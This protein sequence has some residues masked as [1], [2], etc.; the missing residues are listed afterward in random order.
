MKDETTPSLQAR[1][2]SFIAENTS[3]RIRERYHRLAEYADAHT[4]GALENVVVVDTEATGFSFNHDHLIQIAAARMEN[5]EITEWYV[6]FA[7]PGKPIPDEIQ[8]LT[9]ITD[10]QVEQAPTP[11]EAVAGL[12]E[13]VGDMPLVAHN[14]SFDRT[15][16][17]KYETGKV[18]EKNLWLDSLDLARIA[19]PRLTSHRLLDLVR[20]FG[21]PE[22]THRADDDVAATCR[23]YRILLA[24]VANMPDDLVYYIGQSTTPRQWN[25]VEVFR[26]L[27][28]ECSDVL[29]LHYTRRLALREGILRNMNAELTA[30]ADEADEV[31]APGEAAETPEPNET[32]EPGEPSI[33]DASPAATPSAPN[34]TEPLTFVPDRAIVEAFSA[35][36]LVGRSYAH[37]EPR[38]EQAEMAL[39]VHHA[40]E[41]EHNLAVEAG[42]GVGKSMA[43]LVPLAY[44][45]R[46]NNMTVGV[47]TKTNALL[48]QL[49]NHELPLLQ[50]ELG[51]TYTALK[52]FTH[53]PCLYKVERLIEA[54]PQVR[55]VKNEE[56]N[57][58]AA[59]A[60]LL[61]FI[62][63][64]E[65]DDMDNLKMDYRALP[66]YLTTVNSAECMRRRC[67]YYGTK[68]FAVGAREQA[69]KS[70]I[71]LTNHSLLFWDQRL[72]GGLLPAIRH[73]VIDEAHSAEEEA[74][75]AFSVEVS[76][77]ALLSLARRFE[78]GGSV[79]R[80]LDRT[81]AKG[82]LPEEVLRVVSGVCGSVET[83][84]SGLVIAVNE[85]AMA[86]KELLY[87]DQADKGKNKNYERTE[88]WLSNEIRSTELYRE[89]EFAARGVRGML[90]RLARHLANLVAL[91][92]DHD[93]PGQLQRE[94]A[95]VTLEVREAHD[96]VNLI[97]FSTSENNVYSVVLNRQ[98]N[99]F[100]EVF[101]VQPREVG[102]NLGQTL[103]DRSRSVIYTSATLTVDGSFAPFERAMGLNQDEANAAGKGGESTKAAGPARA[104][105]ATDLAKATSAAASTEGE[106]PKPATAELLA[107]PSSYDFDANMKIYVAIDMPD[108]A[109]PSYLEHLQDFLLRLHLA[110]HGSMLTLFTN[111]RDMERCFDEVNPGLKEEGLRLVCQKWGVSTKGLR[112]DFL[113]D[114]TLS[115]FALKS[116]WEG[117]DA[118]GSTLRGV[119]VPKLPFRLP[120]DPLSCEQRALD[121]RAWNHHVLPQAVIEVKQ[122]VGRLI[123][124][125]EDKGIVV[126]ADTRL[127]SKPYGRTFL[128][129]L[130]SKNIVLMTRAEIIADILAN[131][132]LEGAD[133]TNDTGSSVGT[134]TD[135]G[136]ATGTNTATNAAA[137]TTTDAE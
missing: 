39:A 112:D 125:A 38:P 77:A 133:G 97:F 65:Y 52:G 88:L 94:A 40:L 19:L 50:Q 121:P 7:N 56:V 106:K 58:A 91:M 86:A 66:R 93:I 98:R 28:P 129:S 15:F 82:M 79:R 3:D 2:D 132:A 84:G 20:A 23:V 111:R 16:I 95:T 21:G 71:V 61:S 119:V 128:N 115:L 114:K 92:E 4:F 31:G 69:Q 54:G 67:P 14:A 6:T 43:Y 105:K 110:Q 29:D 123:R 108:P 25:T 12:A 18:L 126:F 99:L 83:I 17:T 136:A 68:C 85:L 53:Y 102:G 120:T 87:F 103:Y 48:D 130:P 63:Q 44:A 70:H 64:A 81:D 127:V 116:F 57:Q 49:L 42:T 117:F 74:R 135:V 107:I 33:S 101:R 35:E 122:A 45:A 1:L 118:P 46:E 36:G 51:I 37:Y 104:T 22:S 80:M 32:T 34:G 76:M 134:S 30:E 41:S 72:D 60:T 90:D 78:E 5:G 9:N 137:D 75:R 8:H 96:A 73:W 47:A 27:V 13:F 26:Q 24:A 59:L 113:R 55:T 100:E 131:Q 124:R 62:E 11:E 109:Y 89:V 10:D